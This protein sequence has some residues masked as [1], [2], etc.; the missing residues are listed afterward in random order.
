MNLHRFLEELREGLRHCDV[1][2]GRL[3]VAVSGGADSV[4]LLRGLVH[5]SSAFSLELHVAHLN[6]RL[7][8][9]DSD[10]DATWVKELAESLNLRCEIGVVSRE[11]L[12]LESGGLEENA[13]TLRYRFLDEA[14][15]KLDCQTMVLAHTQDDQVETVLHHVLRGTGVTGLRGIP[16]Q[17]QTVSG[18]RLIRPMLTIRRA[19]LES[20]LVECG[21]SFRTD[22]TNVDTA[23]TR[24]RLRHVLLPIIREQINPQVDSAICRLAEQAAEIDEFFRQAAG[25]LLARSLK[26]RQHDT[27]R[28]DVVELMDQPRHL[29]RE[30]F[31]ALWQLQQWPLQAMG[32][33]HW[34]RLVEILSTHETITLPNRIEARFHSE[35]LLVLRRL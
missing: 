13:R 30:L 25:D 20:Y 1:C 33:D 23:M 7:R 4:A 35:K 14:A 22:V 10:G 34:N 2:S 26:D 11:D 29:V 18:H 19:L 31:R 24:N 9:P 32:F 16:A 17:R 8:G 6:H 12:P 21:Q 28:L 5:L 3:L 27:C 15:A